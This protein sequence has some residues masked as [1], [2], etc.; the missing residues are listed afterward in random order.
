VERAETVVEPP[1]SSRRHRI[2]VIAGDG[3]GPEVVKQGLRVV[4][5]ASRTG[6]FTLDVEELPW[7]ASYFRKTGRMMPADAL[8][9]VEQFDAIYFGAVGSPDVPDDVS[10]WGLLMPIRKHLD[11][12]VNVR[13]IRGFRG[14]RRLHSAPVEDIDIS[15]V[16]ENTEGEY[17]NIGGRVYADEREVAVQTSVFTRRGIARVL[18]YAF[19]L[20]A[21][22]RGIQSVTKSNALAHS[23]TL[24]DEVAY[25]TA[26]RY[27]DVAFERIHVDAAAYRMIVAPQTFQVVVASNLF[28]DIL[29]DLGAGLIGS[30]GLAASA[31]LNPEESRGLFEPVHGSAPDIAGRGIASPIGSILSGAMMLDFLGET[32]VADEIR[33]TVAQVLETGAGT[34]DIGGECG[35][36]EFADEVVS[37]LH[38]QKVRSWAARN[39]RTRKGFCRCGGSTT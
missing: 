29:S 25:D 24:W 12:Y 15:I 34:P 9:V 27:P 38:R 4:D 13:P 37:A 11:L 31:N 16:R 36:A 18:D 20:A 3:V 33:T 14:V 6:G 19:R 7:S 30:L 26:A 10:V 2:C 21:D 39:A 8:S 22:G 23:M 5:E 35:T 28:G 32:S 1:T 17:A